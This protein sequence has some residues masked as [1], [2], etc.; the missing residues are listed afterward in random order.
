MSG[1]TSTQAKR[2]YLDKT[3]K[4]WYADVRPEQFDQLEGICNE[5]QLSR[6]ETLKY[7][8]L[9]RNSTKIKATHI[10]C[11]RCFKPHAIGKVR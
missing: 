9:S 1:K 6:A 10:E 4:R 8:V 7:L 2:R 3:Y 11:A 5:V